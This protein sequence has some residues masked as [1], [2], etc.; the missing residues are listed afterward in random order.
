MAANQCKDRRHTQTFYVQR[1]I[2]RIS[3]TR[4]I[5]RK[6]NNGVVDSRPEYFDDVADGLSADGTEGA[7]VLHDVMR[8]RV[9]HAHVAARVQNGV[10]R[11]LQAH[12]ALVG[13]TVSSPS[14]FVRDG[15]TDRRHD[16]RKCGRRRLANV[17]E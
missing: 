10:R 16:R 8:T 2:I 1:K 9:A 3:E 11:P 17:P 14:G 15:R 6:A 4:T 5:R 13:R 12:D 7:A